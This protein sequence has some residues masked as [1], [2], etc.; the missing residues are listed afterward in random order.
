MSDLDISQGSKSSI[1]L[2]LQ[3]F[4]K[5]YALDI[6]ITDLY[7]LHGTSIIDDIGINDYT[8]NLKMGFQINKTF[9]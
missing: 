8:D 9:N 5:T 4:I 2:G 6:S 3:Y 7:H 1:K